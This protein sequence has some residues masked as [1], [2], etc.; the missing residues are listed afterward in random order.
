MNISRHNYNSMSRAS[1]LK[2]YCHTLYILIYLTPE[3]N[4]TFTN[5]PIIYSDLLVD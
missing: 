1:T 3:R 5:A 4:Q 2:S